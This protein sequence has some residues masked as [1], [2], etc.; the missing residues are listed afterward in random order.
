MQLDSHNRLSPL[1]KLLHWTVA[2]FMI[3]LLASGVY[4]AETSAY[5]V[6]PWHKSFGVIII[7]FV[8]ARI[9]WR[10]K[11]GWPQPASQYTPLEHTLSK[12]V[13][14]LLILG[15]LAMPISGFIMS[16]LGGHGVMVFGIELVARNPNPLDPTK[17]LAHSE[18]ITGLAKGVHYWAGYIII[19]AV[20]LH[21]A[22]AYKHHFID[23]DN[24]LK[25]MLKQ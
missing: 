9:A 2:I 23:K 25:R 6:F 22:G 14:W 21:I 5:G 17:V 1:T 15:T 18:A 13:H 10:V 20:F 19:G 3:C 7:F 16:S 12:V 11:N 8:I 4:M 24:T